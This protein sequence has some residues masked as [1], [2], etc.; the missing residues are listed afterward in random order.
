M[1]KKIKIAVVG[2]GN[3]FSALYQ[4]LHYY[5]DVDPENGHIPGV[6]QMRIGGYHPADIQVVAAFDVDRRKVGRPLNEAIFAAPNCARI[7]CPDVPAGPTVLMGPVLDGVSDHMLQAPEHLSFR[8]SNEDP[9]D[10]VKVLKETKADILVNYLPVG[11]QLATEF[12]AQAAID[13]GCSFMN[14]MP[15]LSINSV[16]WER[17]FI[18]AGLCYI[19]SDMKS[20]CGASIISQI[21]QELAFSRGME[22]DFHSQVNFGGNT[23]FLNMQER[24][25]LKHKKVSK[26]NV[27]RAQNDIHH[28][29]VNSDALFAGPAGYIPFLK[30]NKIANFDIRMRGFGGAPVTLDIKLSVQD[31]EN[32]AGVVV[33]GIR[34]LKVA[35]EMGILGCLRGPSAYFM[36]SPPKQLELAESIMECEALNNRT[37]TKNTSRQTTKESAIAFSEE[38]FKSLSKSDA[39]KPYYE[40][41][42]S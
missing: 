33:D 19:G 1:S 41:L 42:D 34:Y 9:V 31:S 24:E 2:I 12:Y 3:C 17:K 14:C 7:F 35:S 28:V 39:M 11:S 6:M 37:L 38:E 36:K 16:K 13:A 25:R 26:E 4:G 27:I 21:I 5:K 30:D 8:I 32:S 40:L 20:Q 15:V 29:E 22:V 10:V 23:D 18:E